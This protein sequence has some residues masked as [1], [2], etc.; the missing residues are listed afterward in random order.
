MNRGAFY[1][2]DHTILPSAVDSRGIKL[3]HMRCD[4]T[5]QGRRAGRGTARPAR[6]DPGSGW[7]SLMAPRDGA[8]AGETSQ[9]VAEYPAKLPATA[10][11]RICVG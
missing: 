6:E 1:P 8:G 10:K 9:D 3:H 7:H 11:T 5:T 2:T 4:N